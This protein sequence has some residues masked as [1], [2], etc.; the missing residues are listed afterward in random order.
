MK[1]SF[2]IQIPLKSARNVSRVSLFIE[3]GGKVEIWKIKKSETKYKMTSHPAKHFLGSTFQM[4]N[5][6]LALRAGVR[7]TR[8]G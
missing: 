7:V 8:R 3:F 1:M 2:Q 5:L 6:G 4:T